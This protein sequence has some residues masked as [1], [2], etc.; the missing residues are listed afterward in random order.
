MKKR[1]IAFLALGLLALLIIGVLKVGNQEDDTQPAKVKLMVSA[2][3][4]NFS[5]YPATVALNDLV[6]R[7]S[8]LDITVQSVGGSL[9]MPGLVEKDQADILHLTVTTQAEAYFGSGD[10]SGNPH[11]SLRL[12]IAVGELPSTYISTAAT[13]ITRIPDLKGKRVGRGLTMV[14]IMPEA[15]LQAYGLDLDRDIQWS[16]YGATNDMYKDLAFGRI[17]AFFDS[18]EGAKMLSLKEQSRTGIVLLPIERESWEEAAA[19][20]PSSFIGVY[21][22]DIPLSQIQGVEGTGSVGCT[23][24]SMGIGANT[25]LPDDVVYTYVRTLIENQK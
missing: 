5:W 2:F 14:Q 7:H 3:P 12:L 18:I 24:R 10:F 13:G 22:K 6:T 15:F 9:A 19:S 23:V 4:T 16:E 8:N 17:D 1:L 25:N 11:Q 21:H 20:N